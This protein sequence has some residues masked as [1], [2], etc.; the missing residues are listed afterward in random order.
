MAATRSVASERRL[1][2]RPSSGASGWL[3][4]VPPTSFRA[5]SCVTRQMSQTRLGG[6]IRSILPKAA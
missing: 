2:A 3:R 4:A 1:G 5:A 6:M